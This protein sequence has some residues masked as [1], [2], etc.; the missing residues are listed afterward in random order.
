MKVLKGINR[1]LMF[2]TLLLYLTIY[3]GMLLQMVLG[4]C[5]VATALILLFF[6]KI[7]KK[8][9]KIQLIVYW[10]IVIFYGLAWCFGWLHQTAYKELVLFF[11]PMCIAALFT[12][13]LENINQ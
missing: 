4:A 7:F 11:F 2:G 6:W 3:L 1:V 8:S 12:V 9:E 13:F 5:Q 10:M